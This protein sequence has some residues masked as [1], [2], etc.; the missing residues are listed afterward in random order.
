MKNILFDI[1]IFVICIGCSNRSAVDLPEH[2]KNQDL[3]NLTIY[4]VDVQPNQTIQLICE[5]AFGNSEDVLIGNPSQ[6]EADHSGRVYIGDSQQKSIHVFQ[7]D[8]N[9]LSSFGREGQGP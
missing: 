8:G 5:Q 2:I 1:L 6:L 9:Y 7:P 3:D 4:Q